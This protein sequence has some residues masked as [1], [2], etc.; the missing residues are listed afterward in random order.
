MSIRWPCALACGLS[1]AIVPAFLD[2]LLYPIMASAKNSL[3]L[4]ILFVL[5]F[6]TVICTM[7][8]FKPVEE[9]FLEEGIA[10]GLL[11]FFMAIV[12]GFSIVVSFP[13]HVLRTNQEV[14]IITFMLNIGIFFLIVPCITVA[15]GYML[16]S[17]TFS[18]RW[19]HDRL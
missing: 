14:S 1:I 11:W 6:I 15:F 17:K 13:E 16:K 3:N 18:A 8:Y 2:F 9:N 7:R 12:V 5:V 4:L 10:V 19:S